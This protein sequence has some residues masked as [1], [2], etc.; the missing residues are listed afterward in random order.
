MWAVHHVFSAGAD[1][2]LLQDGAH[3]GVVARLGGQAE[4]E[5]GVNR[6]EAVL[7]LHEK[8]RRAVSHLYE[9]GRRGVFRTCSAYASTFLA[10]PMPRPSCGV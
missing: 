7:L 10:S 4:R 8:G 9:K 1:R 5:V 6:V 2:A 3:G